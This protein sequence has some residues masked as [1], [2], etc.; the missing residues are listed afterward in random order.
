MKYTALMTTI[1]Q[2]KKVLQNKKSQLIQNGIIE[3]GIFGSYIRGEER[4]ESDVDILI[5]IARPAKIDLFDLIMIEDELTQELN[6]K[7]DLVIKSNL[8]PIIGNNILSEVEYL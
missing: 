6:T 7:V 8:K 2:V 3:I 5:D 1:Q 4:P